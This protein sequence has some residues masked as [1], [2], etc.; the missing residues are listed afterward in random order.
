MNLRALPYCTLVS[1]PSPH[2]DR[3]PCGALNHH[4]AVRSHF[5]QLVDQ[6]AQSATGSATRIARALLF[7]EPPSIDRGEITEK[8]SINQRMVLQVSAAS[9]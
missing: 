6:L 3:Q 2:L 9:G 8:G 7:A 4:P 1:L 5:Q